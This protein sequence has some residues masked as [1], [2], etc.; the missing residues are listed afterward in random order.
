MN[1]STTNSEKAIAALQYSDLG[2]KVVPIYSIANGKCTCH[3]SD[4]CTSPGKHPL[5]ANGLKDA[6]TDHMQI[7]EWWRECPN[8]NI[9]IVTGKASGIVVLDIDPRHGGNE[10]LDELEAKHG[11]LP[12]TITACTGGGGFH[13]FF[14]H[15]SDE[16]RNRANVRPGIDVRGDGGYVVAPPSNHISRGTY[17]WDEAR[18]PEEIG[19]AE[20]PAWLLEELR[21]EP[22]AD[23]QRNGKPA[24]GHSLLLQRAQQYVANADAA[25]EGYRN[26]A[27]FRLAGHLAAFVDES[28][29]RLGESDILN[30]LVLWNARCVPPLDDSEL[31]QCVTSALNNGKP[32]ESKV[33]TDADILSKLI[34]DKQSPQPSVQALEKFT[35]GKLLTE[36][37]TM[38]PPVVDGLIRQGET[39]NIIAWTKVGKSW[40]SYGLLLAIITGKPWLGRFETT[41]GRV[42]LIDNELHRPTI[43]SRLKIV[44]ESL[45]ILPADI[46]GKL[47]IWPL[48]GQLRPL[49][50]LVAE[51]EDIPEKHYQL[52]IFDAKY[53]F[54]RPGTSENDN[55]EETLVYNLLDLLGEKTKSALS[56]VHHSTKGSQSEKRV[57][58]VGAGAGA[59]SRAADCHLIL[60][61]HEEE[62]AAVLD[63][64]T[65][66]FPPVDPLVLRWDYPLWTPDEYADAAKLKGNLTKRDQQ[67]AERDHE[68]ML[69]IVKVL[70]DGR[71]TASS[72]RSE[73]GISRD[74][75][76]RL[77]GMLRKHDQVVAIPT[78]IRGNETHEYQLS[79]TA[80]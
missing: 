17:R 27:A 54:Q 63:A 53:R 18:S 10:S 14:R 62:G 38:H 30:L 56:L 4:D 33:V 67:Q 77:L 11:T 71:H 26:D 50:E 61:E 3:K 29:T 22:K 12:A 40:L 43:A 19:L 15:P 39:M 58:D 57:T 31:S 66:S 1:C 42:L 65:R 16:I 49:C 73:T 64:A 59:Q 7:A 24:T 28:G 9:G 36:Y 79:E 72:I 32:R 37:P 45:G 5:T 78:T 47:D 8:A 80:D 74:R 51:F 52:I 35:F 2:W 25:G 20:M 69:E 23:V 41:P 68:G 34:F 6:S 55:S 70:G 46:A 76:E 44:C 60:R 13:F 48:R 21:R 75:V